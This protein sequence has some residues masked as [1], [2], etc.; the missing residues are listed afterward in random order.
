MAGTNHRISTLTLCLTAAIHALTQPYLSP[1][2][3]LD[4]A[5]AS[6]VL[7]TTSTTLFV[8]ALAPPTR[9]DVGMRELA[10]LIVFPGHAAASGLVINASCALLASLLFIKRTGADPAL[11]GAVCAAAALVGWLRPLG[12][13][14]TWRLGRLGKGPLDPA[15]WIFP[16]DALAGVRAAMRSAHPVAGLATHGPILCAPEAKASRFGQLLTRALETSGPDDKCMAAALTLSPGGAEGAIVAAPWGRP[17]GLVGAAPLTVLAMRD[18]AEQLSEA[19]D[20][21]R[22]LALNA[23]RHKLERGLSAGLEP[24]AR[25]QSAAVRDEAELL[26]QAMLE[27]Q[28]HFDPEPLLGE[29]RLA[30]EVI[31]RP[32]LSGDLRAQSAQS[33]ALQL[34][35][36]AASLA[37]ACACLVAIA[38]RGS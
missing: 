13:L 15:L 31:Q 9:P 12:I 21:R 25:D 36:V 23:L 19:N 26:S 17:G 24:D 35:L 32:A 18:A 2:A 7:G 38:T 22:R 14:G 28:V 30:I 11:V 20:Q 37:T 34:C 33:L 16:R 4:L 8:S 10:G 27:P 1:T 29:M 3:P 5:L 6:A